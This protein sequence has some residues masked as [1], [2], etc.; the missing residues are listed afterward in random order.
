MFFWYLVYIYI[1][2]FDSS[3]LSDMELVKKK[4]NKLFLF[5]R[6]LHCPSALCL[7][8]LFSFIRS[9]LWIVDFST[10]VISILFRKSSP[11]LMPF[12]V[13][14]HSLSSSA[15]QVLCW[16]FLIHLGLNVVQDGKSGSIYI[17][18]HA[19]IHLD[20]HHLLNMLS[21]FFSVYFWLLYKIRVTM[22]M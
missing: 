18:L 11:V 12:K 7:T 10:W 20:Q 16:D 17:L 3:S 15:C 13:T 5:C 19:A 6:R 4:T 9:C 14:P 8:G 21:F 1:Y 22:G 2:I